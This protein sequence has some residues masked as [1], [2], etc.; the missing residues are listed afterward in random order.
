MSSI[1]TVTSKGQV[2]IPAAIRRALG[3]DAGS[4]VV[5]TFDND[6]ATVTQAPDFLSL[7]GSIDVPAEVRGMAWDDIKA[8][9]HSSRAN[10]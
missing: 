7:A 3:I 5:F 8:L 10:S 9:A 1:A 6:H 2:T 4:R